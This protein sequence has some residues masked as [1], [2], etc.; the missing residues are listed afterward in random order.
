MAQNKDDA[1]QSHQDMRMVILSKQIESTEHLVKL[2]LKTLER[3]S[4]EGSEAQIFMSINLLME[5]LEKSNEQLDAM[6]TE[7]RS[8]ST[9]V[10]NVLAIASKAMGLPKSDKDYND[11]V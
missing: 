11:N 6:M 3:I 9:I 10:G 7:K 5:K 4:L 8:T 2:K 1:D